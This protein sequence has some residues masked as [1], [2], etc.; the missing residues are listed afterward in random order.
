[1]D[2][3]E[4]G[5]ESAV[6]GQGRAPAGPD[7]DGNRAVDVIGGGPQPGRRRSISGW[8]VIVAALVVLL[9]LARL[10]AAK[11]ARTDVQPA[12]GQ[13]AP[14]APTAPT[15]PAPPPTGIAPLGDLGPPLTAIPGLPAAIGLGRQGLYA[16]QVG[17][18]RLIRIVGGEQVNEVPMP[19]EPAG[20][21]VD[22]GA[23]LVWTWST[24]HD[25]SDTI[26]VVR[27]YDARS[28]KQVA[29]ARLPGYPDDAV[30]SGGRLWVAAERLWAVGVDGPARRLSAAHGVP[31]DVAVDARRHRLLVATDS[32]LLA[33]DPR[34]LRV[35]DARALPLGKPSIAVVGN[36]AWV[37]DFRQGP[38]L[39][40]VD[41]ARS[42]L[43]A[44]GPAT[45]W[46]SAGAVV[47][48]G[49]RVVWVRDGGTDTLWCV[50]PGTGALLGEWD[51]IQG[52]V[53]SR[54]GAAWV[55]SAGSVLPLG[56]T[57]SC[58]G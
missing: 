12:P 22:D 42:R 46:L 50:D 7:A 31:F 53:V 32:A 45:R 43:A 57:R 40:H 48:P 4:P 30:A 41:L 8:S 16:A 39:R 44:P 38:L 34:T 51:G 37:G 27:G 13:T 18:P 3:A 26:T 1:M 35:L 5:D 58:S 55:I 47:W 52:P 10:T 56:L 2:T 36:D 9:G 20:I 19:P 6:M 28:L 25:G 23:K 24:T 14:T 17:P 15:V 49:Q 33:V 21:A 54:A 11:D 29:A